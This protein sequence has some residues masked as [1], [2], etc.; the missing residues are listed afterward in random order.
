MTSHVDAVY[1][2]N[3]YR[4]S[5]GFFGVHFIYEIAHFGPLSSEVQETTPIEVKPQ[6]QVEE[7]VKS[8]TVDN[9][10][11]EAFARIKNLHAVII[12]R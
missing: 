2:L 9:L 1:T 10:H 8:F 3:Y 7:F 4:E 12:D 6:T 5:I 11:I